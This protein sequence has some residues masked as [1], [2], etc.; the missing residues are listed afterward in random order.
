MN[1][2]PNQTTNRLLAGILIILAIFFF[3]PAL[4]CL[5]SIAIGHVG[6]T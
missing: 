4:C 3:G 1:N 6:G 2:Q 5:L